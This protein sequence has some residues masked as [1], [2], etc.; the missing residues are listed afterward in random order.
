[1]PDQEY[2]LLLGTA[3]YY[4]SK[5]RPDH[6]ENGRLEIEWETLNAVQ[7][8][9][10]DI[11]DLPNQPSLRYNEGNIGVPLFA[12]P[13]VGD[14]VYIVGRWILDSG[15][16]EEGARTEIHPPRLIA[17]MRNNHTAVPFILDLPDIL[18]RASQV[19]IYVSGNGGGANQFSDALSEALNNNGLGGGRVEDVLGNQLNIYERPGPMDNRTRDRVK[20]LQNSLKVILGCWFTDGICLRNVDLDK[21]FG[22]AGPTGVGL[23]GRGP[24]LRPIND[25]DYEFIV[26]VPPAPP[27]ATGLFYDV[28]T[29][30]QHT[31]EVEEIVEFAQPDPV[32][33][34]PRV[35]VRLPYRGKDNGIYARTLKF[36]WNNFSHP[37]IHLR[38]VMDSIKVYDDADP[39]GRGSGEWELWTDIAGHWFYLT[40]LNPAK[41]RGHVN[42]GDVIG[43]IQQASADIFLDFRER[44]RVFTKG[45]EAD[46][47]ENF[48]GTLNATS[49]QVGAAL[50]KIMVDNNGPGFE[51]DLLGGALFDEASFLLYPPHSFTVTA[52]KVGGENDA[53]PPPSDHGATSHYAMNFLVNEIPAHYPST[54]STSNTVGPTASTRRRVMGSFTLPDRGSAP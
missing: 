34:N 46:D 26:P 22:V 47:I 20:D 36:A 48:F 1:V 51:D 42:D 14:R 54:Q 30:P 52:A 23:G 37:G 21:I 11:Y 5:D 4:A 16:P 50:V 29:H 38:V 24:E 39:G 53:F 18:T 28:D 27:G 19:D 31:T 7:E 43:S 35:R 33:G 9:F 6:R 17:T 15:H 25:M 44:L 10:G 2:Q 8:K 12:M 49:Y 45:Y 40:G 13:T 32:T 41:F 3:N